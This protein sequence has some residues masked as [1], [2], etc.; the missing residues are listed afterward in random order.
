MKLADL[1]VESEGPIVYANLRG[2]IDMSNAAEL[3]DELGAVTPNSAMSLILNLTDVGYLD[4]AGIHFVHRLRE[5]L[6]ASGQRLMLVIPDDSPINAT[7]RLA[8]LDW[9][10]D[11]A[12]TVDAAR[13]TVHGPPPR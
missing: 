12:D 7:I 3:R 1:K 6:R 9:S 10:D 13:E 11:T 8:G 4:S 2:D 5:D